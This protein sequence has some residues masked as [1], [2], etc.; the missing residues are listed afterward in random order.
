MSFCICILNTGSKHLVAR[1]IAVLTSLN[2]RFKNF[3]QSQN[4][5]VLQKS[6]KDLY[7][8]IALAVQETEL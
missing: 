7:D 6:G 1:Y 4:L 8:E 3:S 2:T 5:Y